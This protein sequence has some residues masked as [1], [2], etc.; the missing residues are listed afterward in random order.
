MCEWL[1]IFLGKFSG[2]SFWEATCT[3]AQGIIWSELILD[4]LCE[5]QTVIRWVCLGKIYWMVKVHAMT[6]LGKSKKNIKNS[7]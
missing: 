6:Q 2:E 4:G 3:L 5:S 7:L 1:M